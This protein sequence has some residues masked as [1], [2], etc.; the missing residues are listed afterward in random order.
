M[1]YFE[2]LIGIAS[3][4]IALAGFSGV[5]VA[6]GSRRQGAWLPGDRLRLGFLIEA[7]FTATGFSLISLVLLYSIPETPSQAWRISSGLWAAYMLWSL[8]SSHLQIKKNDVDHD[9][10]D[11]IANKVVTVVF[12]VLIGWQCFNAV[13]SAEFA[14]F[15]AALSFNIAGAAMQFGRLIKS[16]FH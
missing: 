16:A 11:R 8:I 5:V 10:I 12:L 9:D 4:A 15:L 2:T 7:S 3:L 1:E 14:P 13:E 6:F